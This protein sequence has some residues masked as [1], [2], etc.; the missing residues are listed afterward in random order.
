M[1]RV[2]L[3]CEPWDSCILSLV[4]LSFTPTTSIQEP[5]FL[6]SFS[7]SFSHFSFLFLFFSSQ[8]ARWRDRSNAKIAF[9]PV[10][11]LYFVISNKCYN[12]ARETKEGDTISMD[13]AR[14][15]FIVRLVKWTCERNESLSA[16]LFNRRSFR[17][18]RLRSAS[19]EQSTIS[20]GC[21]DEVAWRRHVLLANSCE[22]IATDSASR[23]SLLASQD[24][25]TVR[26]IFY[27]RM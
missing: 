24:M 21:R 14:S 25:R 15:A 20:L 23:T 13:N 26:K 8:P 4:P 11:A 18:A 19:N 10:Y 12:E 5:A 6:F 27:S 22:R 3:L 9:W 17:S 16:H 7:F 1:R 2:H